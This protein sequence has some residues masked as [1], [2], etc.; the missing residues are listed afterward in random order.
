M[1]LQ[2]EDGAERLTLA[3]PNLSRQ[4]K[5]CAAYILEH[6]GDVAT[7]S[8]RQVASRADVLPSNMNRLA[9]SLGF[10]G[11]NEFRD[12]YRN[13]VNENSV[14]YPQKAGQILAAVSESD[15]E[16]TFDTFH[17]TSAANL[18]GLFENIDRN[19]VRSAIDILE[20]ARN[21]TVV[22]MH[23]SYAFAD[24]LHYI[25]A[26]CFRN[27]HLVTRLNGELS[28]RV[29]GLESEDALLAI[30]LRPC[31]ADTIKVARRAHEAGVPVIGITDSRTSPL[32]AYSKVVLLTPKQSPGFFDSY[33]ATTA[34][35]EM[36]IGMIVSGGDSSIVRNID[37]L[38][39]CRHE[40]GEYWV[41]E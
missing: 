41:D 16:N 36:I 33:I 38:E 25:A 30:S 8:M 23:A 4:L 3:F 2:Y 12:I 29:E 22:G 28:D 40:L 21:V 13:S 31:A 18:D 35:I 39:R 19:S 26:M 14:S 5:K 6:P 1:R 20:D 10:S 27:W 37:R 24:Y 9:R 34:L 32:A 11:Y 17:R 15:F 7:L